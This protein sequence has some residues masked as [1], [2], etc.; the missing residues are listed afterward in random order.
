MSLAGAEMT[1]RQASPPLWRPVTSMPYTLTPISHPDAQP[2]RWP[3]RAPACLLLHGLTS[4]PW[5]VR[6]VGVALRDAGYHAESIWLPGHG[7]Q[8]EDLA[9]LRWTDWTAAVDAH[10][11][12]MR[13]EHGQVAV[14]GSSLGGTLALWAASTQPVAAVVTM[15]A[16]VSLRR[17]ARFARL[18]AWVR[19]FPSKR[20]TGSAI[21]DDEARERHPAYSRSSLHAVAEMGKLNRQ[22]RERI[23]EIRAPLLVMHARQ[24]TVIAADN[25][26]WI[27]QHAGSEVKKLLWLENSDHIITEDFDHL[28]VTRA[29]VE[30]IEMVARSGCG[31]DT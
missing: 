5:E 9:K 1:A 21:F 7:T 8:V 23:R 3:G 19:P 6:P 2:F 30:W 17:A 25:A 16:A 29:A 14:M 27:K 26:E 15:G 4:T 13:R 31:T 18:L 10:L 22:V 24:D 12:A 28:L 11:T 20:P